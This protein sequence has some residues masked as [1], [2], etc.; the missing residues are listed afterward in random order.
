MTNRALWKSSMP[1]LS[2][3]STP[4]FL[5]LFFIYI[6]KVFSFFLS[7]FFTF[8]SDCKLVPSVESGRK[9]AHSQGCCRPTSTELQVL[10]YSCWTARGDSSP[11]V[12]FPNGSQLPRPG[13]LLCTMHTDELLGGLEADTR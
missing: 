9:G 12:L 1:M 4:L 2:P 10:R 13:Q 5:R 3:K 6:F 8:L 7:F 11:S